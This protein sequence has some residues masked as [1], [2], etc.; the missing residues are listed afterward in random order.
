MKLKKRV[1]DIIIT[2][3]EDAGCYRMTGID[4]LEKAKMLKEKYFDKMEDPCR[5]VGRLDDDLDAFKTII[6][7]GFDT[8]KTYYLPHGDFNDWESWMGSFVCCSDY[9][10]AKRLCDECS[11]GSDKTYSVEE[12]WR[13]ATAE[14]IEKY[15]VYNTE[16]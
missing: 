13:E 2:D 12:N 16:A 14:E 7:E 4:S 15:G 8:E 3:G 10:E 5:I 6:P 11:E 1:Y 9:A